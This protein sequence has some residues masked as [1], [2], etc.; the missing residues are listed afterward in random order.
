MV[1]YYGKFGECNFRQYFLVGVGTYYSSVQNHFPFS[2]TSQGAKI[3]I[4]H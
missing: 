1:E 2:L 4:T 3:K